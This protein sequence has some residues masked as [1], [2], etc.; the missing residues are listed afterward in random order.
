[1]DAKVVIQALA[2]LVGAVFSIYQIRNLLP[3]SRVALKL[4]LEI[5][6]LLGE[7]HHKY[8]NLKRDID[9]RLEAMFPDDLSNAQDVGE[10]REEIGPVDEEPKV[11]SWGDF[12]GGLVVLIVS[13]A[14]T[15]GVFSEGFSWLGVVTA[16]LAFA[17]V[18][19]IITGIEGKRK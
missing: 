1:M 12:I 18:G 5:L 16:L 9:N 10:P 8:D 19:G 2:I 7:N 14:W 6:S 3:R 15:I 11:K 13:F 4:D 17:G